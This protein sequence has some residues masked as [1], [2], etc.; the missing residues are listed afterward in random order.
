M[1][2]RPRFLDCARY[3]GISEEPAPVRGESRTTLGY[4]LYPVCVKKRW[5]RRAVR[6][7]EMIAD[8][9][10]F[11]RQIR[12]KPVVRHVQR[13]AATRRCQAFSVGPNGVID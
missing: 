12:F 7:T 1:A 8:R 6:E 9:P 3:R 5:R 10:A 2:V 13:F 11:L 4:R